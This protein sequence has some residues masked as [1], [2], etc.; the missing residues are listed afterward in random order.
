ME[1]W[2]DWV[3][4]SHLSQSEENL[5]ILYRHFL[6]LNQALYSKENKDI[7]TVLINTSTNLIS[8]FQ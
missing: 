3:D 2:N 8:I 6:E 7:D 4:H 5:Y 1:H